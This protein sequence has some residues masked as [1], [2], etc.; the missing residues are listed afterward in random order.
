MNARSRSDL[1]LGPH[2]R[3]PRFYRTGEPAGGPKLALMRG[4]EDAG[5]SEYLI[6]M[7][8]TVLTGWPFPEIDPTRTRRPDS[9][10][11]PPGAPQ[12][13]VYQRREEDEDGP[14]SARASAR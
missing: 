6:S 4:T 13:Y 11:Q 3:K 5:Q 9:T 10:R 12:P 1:P 14:S 7:A 2:G 8:A